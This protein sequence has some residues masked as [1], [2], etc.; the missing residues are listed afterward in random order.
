MSVTGVIGISSG[1]MVR[2]A[3]FYDELT[4]VDRPE[5]T[6]VSHVIA[7]L[8]HES[9]NQIAEKALTVGAEWVWYVDD[10]HSFHAD[11]LMRL[12]AWDVSIVSGLYLRRTYPFKPVLYEHTDDNGEVMKSN[13]TPEDVGLKSV[14][15]TGAGCLLVRTPVFKALRPPYFRFTNTENGGI[16]GEDIDFCRRAREKSF[17]VY[18]DF[19]TPVGHK[20]TITLYPNRESV[21]KWSVRVIDL[22]GK[23]FGRGPMEAV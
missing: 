17:P 19:D 21:G 20:T 11:T 22:A 7:P 15:A 1:E 16:L 12:L 13:F 18:C 14:L 2:H 9:R 23:T 10:D 3:S 6:I 5:G 8:V 4:Y